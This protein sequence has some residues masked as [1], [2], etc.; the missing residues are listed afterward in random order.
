MVPP[1][2][3]NDKEC[4]VRF[5]TINS[6]SCFSNSTRT[7]KKKKL[8]FLLKN[9]NLYTGKKIIVLEFQLKK[10]AI[11]NFLIN[12]FGCVWLMSGR[13]QDNTY[14]NDINMFN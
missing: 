1:L 5:M 2:P 10:T 4:T 12:I 8:Y 11:Q 13:I 7:K 6:S 14:R 3:L 9:N